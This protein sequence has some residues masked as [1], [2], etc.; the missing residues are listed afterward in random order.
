MANYAYKE[1]KT[2]FINWI[3]SKKNVTFEDIV[4]SGIYPNHNELLLKA[5]L[6]SYC[7]KNYIK[8]ND[9]MTFSISDKEPRRNLP[10]DNFNGNF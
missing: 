2:A 7:K 3:T 5:L 10:R 6:R 4:K 8:R 9:D 1:N